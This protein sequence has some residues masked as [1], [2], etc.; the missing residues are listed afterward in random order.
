[1]VTRRGRRLEWFDS[2]LGFTTIADGGQTS[3]TLFDANVLGAIGVK[4]ATITRQIVKIIMRPTV[5]VTISELHYGITIVNADALT[6]SAIPE[7]DVVSDRADWMVR[8]WLAAFSNSLSDSTQ[9]DRVMADIRTQR[10]MRS[11]EDALIVI[12]DNALNGVSIQVA[13]FIR[14]LIRMP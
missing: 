8:G 13:H 7:A 6:A 5:L 9:T 14:T 11:E 4:G 2:I 12:Y 10:I 3:Q 1:M